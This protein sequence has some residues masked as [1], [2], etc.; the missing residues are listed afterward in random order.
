MD[1]RTL[2]VKLTET[3]ADEENTQFVDIFPRGYVSILAGEPG[4]GKTWFMLDKARTYAGEDPMN[5][6]FEPEGIKSLI[7]CGET[8]SELL[9]E[10]MRLLGFGYN[11][12]N[13]I[14]YSAETLMK[15][16]IEVV[17]N[18]AIG[19]KNIAK[20]CDAHKPDILWVDTMLSF[21]KE[22][23][24]E[25]KQAD[26][27]DSIRGMARIA[28]YF[29]TAVVL[30]HHFRKRSAKENRAT[31]RSMDDVI[32]TSA[33]TRLAAMVATIQKAGDFKYVKCQKSWWK[34]FDAFAYK[35]INDN[36]DKVTISYERE[37]NMTG[38]IAQ[39]NTTNLCRY[40]MQQGLTDFS[41]E[42]IIRTTKAP[43]ST[44]YKA[45]RTLA[46]Q[47]KIVPTYRIGNQQCY[48]IAQKPEP[49]YN[50]GINDKEEKDNGR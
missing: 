18:T 47:G 26:I 21:I 12:D 22:G 7:L 10:R 6:L 14:V 50:N 9:A 23:S 4:V 48:R 5:S 40:I 17:I 42:T 15:A 34:E 2:G 44:V 33:I 20:I 43:Q 8:R 16:S 24:D 19:R 13:V 25:S 11:Q 3:L 1:V 41:S 35:I 45:I 28:S 36:D 27:S 31:E 39:S 32:G 49:M 38:F 29:N 46:T 30:I 37:G